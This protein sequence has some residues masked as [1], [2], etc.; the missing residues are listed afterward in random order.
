[1]EGEGYDYIVDNDMYDPQPTYSTLSSYINLHNLDKNAINIYV[2]AH[3]W[4][5]LSNGTIGDT[6]GVAFGYDRV[7]YRKNVFPENPGILVHEIGHALGLRHTW[8]GYGSSNCE[9]VTRDPNDPDYNADCAGDAV[10]D[11][12]AMPMFA[13][14][15][16]NHPIDTNCN[17]TGTGTDCYGTPYTITQADVK[18]YMGYLRQDCRQLFTTGQKIRMRETMIHPNR[19]YYSNI[20]EA[21]PTTDLVIYDGLDDSG[22]E[23][24]YVTDPIWHSTDIWVRNQSDGFLNQ[25]HQD[26]MF[27]K[28]SIRSI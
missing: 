2:P 21:N 17:Y 7:F 22:Q 13:P 16:N 11:T 4:R 24:N 25:Q 19:S 9:A 15:D 27:R 1:M 28:Q 23:P 10:T 12:N 6:R 20:I 26:L 3:I 18:N 8:F 14:Y 5:Y